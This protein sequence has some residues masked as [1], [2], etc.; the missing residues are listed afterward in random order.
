MG[1]T[2]GR[3]RNT[4][5]VYEKDSEQGEFEH[6]SDGLTPDIHTAH[7]GTSHHAAHLVRSITARDD[8]PRT[9]IHTAAAAATNGPATGT[10]RPQ[11]II[12][13]LTHHQRARALVQAQ[14]RA[15]VAELAAQ[16]AELATGQ[17]WLDE[18]L[19]RTRQRGRARD[20]G[21]DLSL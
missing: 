7:R 10:T 9:L 15:R 8:R 14:H 21:P 20:T 12:E 3:D 4:A 16:T 1:L 13:L 18:H 6:S 19:T 5:F 17:H 11:Q 2:R